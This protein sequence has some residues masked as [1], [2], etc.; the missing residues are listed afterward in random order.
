MYE[1]MKLTNELIDIFLSKKLCKGVFE[2]NFDKCS[3]S[4]KALSTVA[5]SEQCIVCKDMHTIFS[6]NDCL[7]FAKVRYKA[8]KKS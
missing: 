3:L 6:M 4:A 7:D 2:V 1:L 5:S 8:A